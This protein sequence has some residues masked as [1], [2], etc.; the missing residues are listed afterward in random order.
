MVNLPDNMLG[1]GSSAF[2]QLIGNLDDGKG[3]YGLMWKGH[4]NELEVYTVPVSALRYNLRN[5]RVRP[6]LGQYVSE[7]KLAEDYWDDVDEEA[8]S[9]QRII[10]GFLVKNPDRKKCLK[11]FKRGEEQIINEPLVCTPGGKVING[12][13][14]LSVYRELY[15][16]DKGKYS[17][18]EH[19]YVAI[20]PNEGAFSD[21]RR[22]ESAFQLEGLEGVPFDW[23]QQGLQDL[24][25]VEG[26]ETTEQ[27]AQRSNRVAADVK[28]SVRLILLAREFL[29]FCDRPECWQDL[30]ME[31][32]VDQAINTL[33]G[34]LNG[35]YV[36]TYQD[37]NKL[38]EI[39]FNVMRDQ[40]AT[41]GKGTSV[42][43]V[44]IKAAAELDAIPW[45]T[46]DS[47]EESGDSSKGEDIDPMLEDVESG[48][49]GTEQKE[50]IDVKIKNSG[51]IV[52]V[53]LIA[54]ERTEED[55]QARNQD[56]YAKRQIKALNSSLDKIITNWELQNTKG[57]K[58][59][60]KNAIK[61]LEKI[62]DKL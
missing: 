40:D 42:H 56:N 2:K 12:N 57:I 14:R 25:D 48:G 22:L 17:H 53:V 44:I 55:R 27:V 36:K 28:K 31:M 7:N 37:R 47:S 50:M 59:S 41:K 1:L 30:R 10:H 51:D 43:L 21:E 11:F 13:Q 8:K 61:K 49:A 29:F 39:S 35:K 38:K 15:T 6:W 34:Q 4:R 46:D 18:L 33:D 24:A 20:L 52:D 23:I 9:I 45:G 58:T 32:K 54:A 19:A 62:L 26:G 60:V 3:L 5:V 16:S